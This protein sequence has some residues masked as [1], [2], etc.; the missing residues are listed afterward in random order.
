MNKFWT[1]TNS[2]TTHTNDRST[3]FNSL[4]SAIRE[5]SLRIERGSTE[6]VCIL[7]CVKVV[8]RAK[9]PCTIEDVTTL[10]PID[11]EIE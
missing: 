5:A 1:V 10:S 6:A 9:I 11:P 7:E 8:K 3:R 2:H 4:E